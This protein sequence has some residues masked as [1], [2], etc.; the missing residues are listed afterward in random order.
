MCIFKYH[1]FDQC[2]HRVIDATEYCQ[3]AKWRA[4]MTGKLAPCPEVV[5]KYH[6]TRATEKPTLLP[7]GFTPEL[8]S[9]Y[10]WMGAEGMCK[11]CTRQQK[12]CWK[13]FILPISSTNP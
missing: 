5:F 1:E 13:P 4:G 10:A 9:T 2:G 3:K 11:S 8:A 7:D 12:V 6:L